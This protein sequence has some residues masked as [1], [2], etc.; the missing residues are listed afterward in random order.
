MRPTKVFLVPKM[1]QRE[2]GNFTVLC[3]HEDSPIPWERPIF[4]VKDK[5]SR[6]WFCHAVR[7]AM[8]KPS[9]QVLANVLA[10]DNT[11]KSPAAIERRMKNPLFVKAAICNCSDLKDLEPLLSTVTFK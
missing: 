6:T 4:T 11:P 8:D 10:E 5:E 2:H 9:L 3:Y 1:N 7:V